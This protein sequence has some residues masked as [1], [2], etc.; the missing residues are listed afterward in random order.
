[1]RMADIEEECT[2]RRKRDSVSKCFEL[3]STG[4]Y[5]GQRTEAEV[6][7]ITL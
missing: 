3:A 4:Q 6:G 5:G 7:N 2:R 1:M